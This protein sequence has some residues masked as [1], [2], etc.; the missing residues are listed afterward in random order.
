MTRLEAILSSYE[1]RGELGGARTFDREYLRA[2]LGA[3]SRQTAVAFW[4]ALFAQFSVF[5]LTAWFALGN[6]GNPKVLG[7][8]LAGGGG[9]VGACSW[10]MVRLWK[11]KI[12]T[13]LTIALV[14][15]LNESTAIAT[16]NVVLDSLRRQRT[17]GTKKTANVRS[18]HG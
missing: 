2:A 14:S 4:A 9:G 7:F 16:L 15:S 18:E 13:D 6:A 10:A 8:I 11:E 17:A 12:S 3:A 1:V 5:I